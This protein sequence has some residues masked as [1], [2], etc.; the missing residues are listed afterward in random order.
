MDG[1]STLGVLSLFRANRTAAHSL[2][3]HGTM[4]SLSGGDMFDMF[5]AKLSHPGSNAREKEEAQLV[6]WAKF[7]ELVEGKWCRITLVVNT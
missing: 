2:C 3:I 5:Q 6:N 7:L 4:T 1:L